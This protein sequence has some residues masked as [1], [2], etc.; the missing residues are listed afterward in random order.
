LLSGLS[1]AACARLP[2]GARQYFIDNYSCP[3]ARVT[4]VELRNARPSEVFAAEWR[5][6]TP[7]DEV[8]SDPGRMAQWRAAEDARRKGWESWINSSRLFQVSGCGH[9]LVL[10]CRPPGQRS[11]PGVPAICNEAPN[12][13]PG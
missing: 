13:A 4:L 8:R 10:A 12:R 5:E 2:D 7:S 9:S 11:T 3:A 1:L 6:A